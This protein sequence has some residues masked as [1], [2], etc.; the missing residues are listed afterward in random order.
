MLN[1]FSEALASFI[2][3]PLVKHYEKKQA[4][5]NAEKEKAQYERWIRIKSESN[6]NV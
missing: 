1:K 6:R 4:E 3:S 5:Q 2:F